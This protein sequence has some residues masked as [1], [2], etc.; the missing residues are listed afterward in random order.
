[1]MNASASFA[2]PPHTEVA[3][4][5]V[6]LVNIGMD[7]VAL[8]VFGVALPLPETDAPTVHR[9]CTRNKQGRQRALRAVRF[10]LKV[11]HERDAIE[12][13]RRLEDHG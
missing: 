7:M 12:E 6:L 2:D 10:R 11:E 13:A 5:T 8:S 3:V 4:R 9:E 1:M